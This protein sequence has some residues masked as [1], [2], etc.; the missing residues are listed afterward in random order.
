VILS[1]ANGGII[2]NLELISR[3]VQW[4]TGV[5]WPGAELYSYQYPVLLG[6][7][8]LLAVACAIDGAILLVQFRRGR[9]AFLFTGGR[10]KVLRLVWIGLVLAAVVLWWLFGFTGVFDPQ[11]R[12]LWAPEPFL[13]VSVVGTLLAAGLVVGSLFPRKREARNEE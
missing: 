10:H 1:N 6:L 5:A 8:G 9:R 4:K 7:A 11:A 12:M 2:L 3:W 13:Y